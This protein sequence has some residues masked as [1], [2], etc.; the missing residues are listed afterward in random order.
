MSLAPAAVRH[1][2]SGEQRP[3]AAFAGQRVHAVAGIGDPRRFFA[4]LRAAGLDP[5]EHAF[6]DHH[7]FSPGE[8]RFGDDAPVL[9][10]S[11]D[12]VKCGAMADPRLWEVPVLARLEPDAGAALI[13]RLVSLA[14]AAGAKES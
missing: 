3:L 2:A 14:R 10:T 7:A 13:D 11:K 8:L 12:A 4:M 9:M 6:P 1:I 5:V